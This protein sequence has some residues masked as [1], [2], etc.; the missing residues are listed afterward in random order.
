MRRLQPLNM[1]ALLQVQTCDLPDRVQASQE[2]EISR[3]LAIAWQRE[4]QFL[5]ND[6]LAESSN[7]VGTRDPHAMH[8][9]GYIN[10]ARC[11]QQPKCSSNPALIGSNRQ[12]QP[13]AVSSVLNPQALC[14]PGRT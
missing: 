13:E 2:F 4:S 9:G 5:P 12:Q 8:M 3:F 11:H 14:P 7:R 10:P 1:E 6:R